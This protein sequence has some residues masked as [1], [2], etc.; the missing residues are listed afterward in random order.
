VPLP[1]DRYVHTVGARLHKPERRRVKV[2]FTAYEFG[3]VRRRRAFAPGSPEHGQNGDAQ[4]R[5]ALRAH[6]DFGESGHNLRRTNDGANGILPGFA[7]EEDVWTADVGLRRDAAS[8]NEQH[9]ADS[10]RLSRNK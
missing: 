2:G 3:F 4:D 7:L 10:H 8:N 5:L 6:R 1:L 9:E